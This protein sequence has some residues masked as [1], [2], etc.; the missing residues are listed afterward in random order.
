MDRSVVA[1]FVALFL[2]GNAMAVPFTA[3]TS[4]LAAT[5]DQATE[6][7]QARM[8]CNL[9]IGVA[10]SFCHS[11]FVELFHYKR[12]KE[13]INYRAGYM[14]S[15][16]VMAAIYLVPPIVVF[17][18]IK[19]KSF[20]R[21]EDLE[22]KRAGLVGF[23]IGMAKLWKNVFSTLLNVPFAILTAFY[24]CSWTAVQLLQNN[25]Y[26][27]DKYVVRRE[28][29]FMW[30]L[31]LIQLVAAASLF[32]WSLV[33]RKIGKRFTFI[34]GLSFWL[35]T[36]IGTFWMNAKTPLWVIYVVAAIS[37][38]GASVTFLIP[39]SMIPDIIDADEVAT[40][41]RREGVFYSLFVLFQKVGL[42]IALAAS[43]Y[44]IGGS[45]YISPAAA[46]PDADP[47]Y[48]PPGVL[49][50]LRLVSGPIPGILVFLAMVICFFYPLGRAKVAENAEI[51]KQRRADA[52]NMSKPSFVPK[53]D[54]T[55][56]DVDIDA[57]DLSA[58]EGNG[59][60]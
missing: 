51:L 29:N 19:E 4:D 32:L 44:A 54:H 52:A 46:Q 28:S 7:T 17:F 47:L 38:L 11:I 8:L 21:K 56:T 2:L 23:L 3:L 58:Q 26:L 35:C 25:L 34:I 50:T 30:I 60:H 37:A 41:Q 13:A 48:Q 33:S 36:S 24:F 18:G 5:Y 40:G 43:S 15:A 57:D 31:L 9:I 12:S 1:F 10:S 39:W 42:A 49:L 27:Y 55:A 59:L 20:I 45:G 6:L 16:F 22:A 14:L 53:S